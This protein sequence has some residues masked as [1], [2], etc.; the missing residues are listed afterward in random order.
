MWISKRALAAV[1]ATAVGATSMA[2]AAGAFGAPGASLR[3]D[4]SH[5]GKRTGAPLIDEPLAPSSHLNPLDPTFHGVSPGMVNWAL[6]RGEVRLKRDGKL[7]LRVKGLVIQGTATPGGVTTI[8]ASLYCGDASTAAV[9]TTPSVPIS[10]KGDARIHDTH[11]TVPATCLA[12]VI[13]VHPNG[14][15]MAYIALDGWRL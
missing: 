15:T 2:F 11:F 13:L 10:R 5:Q 12:P 7:D 8:S 14:N 6:K 1:L 3:S 4:P 9:D